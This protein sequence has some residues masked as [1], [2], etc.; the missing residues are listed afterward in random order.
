MFTNLK[1]KLS[2]IEK[3]HG[4][5]RFDVDR[6]RDLETANSSKWELGD[7][8]QPLLRLKETSV[9]AMWQAIGESF[10]S[11][12]EKVIGYRK[13]KRKECLDP[14]VYQLADRKVE[15]K[16]QIDLNQ[17]T[18]NTEELDRNSVH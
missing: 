1:L 13:N 16:K 5:K 4:L 6:L 2:K 10:T 18:P 14:S 15:I 12:G 8:F 7:K 17:S 11:T 3:T 9:E